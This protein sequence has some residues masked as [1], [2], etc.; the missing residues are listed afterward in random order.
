MQR[1]NCWRSVTDGRCT[2][3]FDVAMNYGVK[4]W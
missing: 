2:G 1:E 4:R 3:K